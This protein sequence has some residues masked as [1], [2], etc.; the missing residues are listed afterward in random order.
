MENNGLLQ[1][2]NGYG[3]GVEHVVEEPRYHYERFL[4]AFG[5]PLAPPASGSTKL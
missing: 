3:K 5:E 4:L 1:V 2:N